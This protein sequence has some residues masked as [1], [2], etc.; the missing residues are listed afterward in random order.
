VTLTLE[1]SR[2]EDYKDG[3]KTLTQ[4]QYLQEKIL[5]LAARFEISHSIVE[6]LIILIQ[7]FH[8]KDYYDDGLSRSFSNI[9]KQYGSKYRGHSTSASL[10]SFRV[11]GLIK[12]VSSLNKN[13]C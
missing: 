10:L 11:R 3:Y 12:L 7:S 9:L 4:L 2:P 1:F 6:K 8:A 13:V 5:P